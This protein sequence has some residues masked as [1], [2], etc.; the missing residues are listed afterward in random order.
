MALREELWSTKNPNVDKYGTVHKYVRTPIY[1]HTDA[2]SHRD[3]RRHRNRVT[4]SITEWPST[5]I[6]DKQLG[7][8]A[9]TFDAAS[10]LATQQ[11]CAVGEGFKRAGK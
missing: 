4:A 6:L 2:D 10:L 1:I 11:R 9:L 3:G 7:N 5:C 8:L